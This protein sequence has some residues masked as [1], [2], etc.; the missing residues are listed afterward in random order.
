MEDEKQL[1]IE[2]QERE[3]E[4]C[5]KEI[6]SLKRGQRHSEANYSKLSAV[7]ENKKKENASV[8]TELSAQKERFQAYYEES[9][10][11][12][13]EVNTWPEPLGVP[14]KDQL[15]GLQ[16]SISLFSQEQAIESTRIRSLKRIF[17]RMGNAE[18]SNR[19]GEVEERRLGPDSKRMHH[20][21]YYLLAEPVD[22]ERNYE[23]A[24]PLHE[25][26]W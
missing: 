15:I 24:F 8:Q 17:L 2:N 21:S 19:L 3:L 26:I 4:N 1:A 13:R 11:K 16:E 20:G 6:E 7:A 25:W 12:Q 10:L 14:K 9:D 22:L 18:E 5:R 23:E